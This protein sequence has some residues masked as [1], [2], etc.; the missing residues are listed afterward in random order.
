[1]A[2]LDISKNGYGVEV[3]SWYLW[4]QEKA[5]SPSEINSNK[6]INRKENITLDISAVDYM[7]YVDKYTSVANFS[8]FE[9]FFDPTISHPAGAAGTIIMHVTYT[10][11]QMESVSAKINSNGY[12]EL[13]IQQMGDI[14]YGKGNNPFFIDN[15]YKELSTNISHYTLD[16]NSDNYAERAFVFGST[17]MTFTTGDVRFLINATTFEPEYIDN[18]QIKPKEDNFDFEGGGTTAKVANHY[19]N[20]ITD[21]S[22]IGKTITLRFIETDK[23]DHIKISKDKFNKLKEIYNKNVNTTP[24]LDAFEKYFN[25]IIVKSGVIDYID[26]NGKLVMFGSN[27][28]DTMQDTKAKNLDFDEYLFSELGGINN[29]HKNKLKNGITY[30]GGKGSDTII[31]TEFDDILYS[32]DKSLKD[33]N[34]PDILK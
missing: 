30:I 1:M 15:Q 32:N 13:N 4:G 26:D 31:G 5:P 9:K 7:K 34:S 8:I 22:N 6:W 25:N 29:P 17:K 14:I 21:P 12:Y 18:L 2:T 28:A 3:L 33:D 27:G 10:K 19:L 20:K 11:A 24:N 16:V 23:I